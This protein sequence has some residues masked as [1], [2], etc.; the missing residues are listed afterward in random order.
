MNLHLMHLEAA[1]EAVL[2]AIDRAGQT[3][4]S[5]SPL[6]DG[7]LV[8]FTALG[9]VKMTDNATGSVWNAMTG[10]CESGPMKGKRL[11][12][13]AD[14]RTIVRPRRNPDVERLAS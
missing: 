5:F 2:V 11:E 12:V 8:R 4:R 7:Q 9:D 3:S 14:G 13:R 10:E 1:G 6:V